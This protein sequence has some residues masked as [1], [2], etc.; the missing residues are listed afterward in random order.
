MDWGYPQSVDSVKRTTDKNSQPIVNSSLKLSYHP[1][2]MNQIPI[3]CLAENSESLRTLSV[4]WQIQLSYFFVG[5]MET[6]SMTED[7][8]GIS[9]L[10]LENKN[11]S[12]MT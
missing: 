2:K 5:E 12:Q 11:V 1:D 10:N 7:V 6:R 4:S 9:I 8:S 3:L